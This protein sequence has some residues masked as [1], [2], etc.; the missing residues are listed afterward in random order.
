MIFIVVVHIRVPHH[1]RLF[2]L[3]IFCTRVRLR[4]H[5]I[6]VTLRVI[7]ESHSFS[8]VPIRALNIYLCICL[9]IYSIHSDTPCISLHIRDRIFVLFSRHF[10]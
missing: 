3:F 4:P 1:I 10:M 5:S 7:L 9:L 6:I 2:S 8:I